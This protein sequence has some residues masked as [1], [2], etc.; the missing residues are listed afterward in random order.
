MI[1]YNHRD[2]CQNGNIYIFNSFKRKYT[3]SFYNGESVLLYYGSRSIPGEYRA[4]LIDELKLLVTEE[5]YNTMVKCGEEEG[6]YDDKILI[7]Y[8]Y[9]YATD[10]ISLTEFTNHY[11]DKINERCLK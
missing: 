9:H 10:S 1:L 11:Y 8:W 5:Y 3:A 6:T 4:D 2:L 7:H